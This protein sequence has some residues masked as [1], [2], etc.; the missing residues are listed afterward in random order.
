[1]PAGRQNS[2]RIDTMTPASPAASSRFLQRW[3]GADPARQARLD[4]LSRLSLR[5]ADLGA[6]LQR[7]LDAGLPLPRAMRRLRNLLVGAIIVRD[8]G[9]LADLDEVVKAMTVFADFAIRTHVAALSS[10]LEAAHGIPVGDETGRHQHLIVLSMGKGGGGELNVSSDIDL[11]FVYPEDGETAAGAGQRQ[12]SNHE[13]FV[14]LGR[15]L[16]A[17]LSEVIEDGFTF[18]VDMALRPNGNSG[19]LAASLAMVEEYLI[20][21]GREWERYA[22]VKARAV[23]GDPQDIAALDAVVRPFVFRRYLDFGVIDAIRNMHAQIRA[24]VKR[25]ERLHPERSHNVSWAAAESARSSSW[26]RCSS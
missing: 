7:E 13:F 26:P 5:E 8:L 14:R 16:S 10:E 12:L 20:V 21:Q 4:E 17:A 24:E 19:P 2:N 11:I 25:Q 23:T 6:L 15:R 18:R 1:M 3:L 22:W 9:G